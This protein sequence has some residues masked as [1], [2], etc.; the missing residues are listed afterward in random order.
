MKLNNRDRHFDQL[1][2]E[3]NLQKEQLERD[4]LLIEN[5][6][7]QALERKRM[8][9]A[10]GTASANTQG[11]GAG[12]DGKFAYPSPSGGRPSPPDATH[13]PGGVGVAGADGAVNKSPLHPNIVESSPTFAGFGAQEFSGRS[14]TMIEAS[15]MLEQD[16][17]AIMRDHEDRFW[18]FV[19]QMHESL[20]AAF[21][22]LASLLR[23]FCIDR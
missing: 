10:L 3:M 13:A 5:K 20:R 8:L 14:G 23:F 4:L 21:K 22:P 1:I 19:Q 18:G 9:D 12:T 15:D 17:A 7:T 6:Y 11:Q 16:A 2:M